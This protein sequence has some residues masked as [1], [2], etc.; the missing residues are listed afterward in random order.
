MR[1]RPVFQPYAD[2]A[3]LEA[4]LYSREEGKY[5]YPEGDDVPQDSVHYVRPVRKDL[6]P[7]MSGPRGMGMGRPEGLREAEPPVTLAEAVPP[8]ILMEAALPVILAGAVLPATLAGA[9]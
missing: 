4:I 7:D 6:E 9:G 3:G 8:A 1:R 5:I 2:E